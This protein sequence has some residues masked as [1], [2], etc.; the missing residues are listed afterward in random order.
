MTFVFTAVLG[1]E[2]AGVTKTTVN[3]HAYNEAIIS[4]VMSGEE[5]D[6]WEP[7]LEKLQDRFRWHKYPQ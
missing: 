7:I 6:K 3:G 5:L 2:D 4:I 1:N